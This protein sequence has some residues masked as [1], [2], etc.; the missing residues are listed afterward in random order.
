M[1]FEDINLS[2]K[3]KFEELVVTNCKLNSISDFNFFYLW[4]T[5]S[6]IQLAFERNFVIAKGVW[7]GKSYFY[8]PSMATKE[9][10]EQILEL[11]EQYQNG[12]PFY[13][14]GID[15]YI[16]EQIQ[17]LPSNM[18][19]KLDR[20]ASD[21]L[22]LTSDLA[23]LSGKK[24][25]AKRNFVNSFQR[26]Y[27]Y[28][29]VQYEDKYFDEILALYDEWTVHSEHA[30]DRKEKLAIQ[31]ALQH[32]KP[33]GLTILL[34]LV[35][36]KVVAF[37]VSAISVHNVAQTFFEKANINF[38]GVYAM[39]NNLTATS[40]LDKTEYINREED[41]GIEGLRTAKLSYNPAVIYDKY[42]LE[43]KHNFCDKLK[44]LLKN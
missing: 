3:D 28:Q 1:T 32:H 7:G 26:S 6:N 2:H 40:L 38:K 4:N 31:T 21:Y 22:Y 18:S 41:M 35:D 39:I 44:S 5:N 37:S 17:Q 20:N 33:L 24:F 11:I 29:L 27:K 23:N 12:K 14:A 43:C 15:S 19:I 25:H 13:F 9:D 30:V 8:S 34:L 16:A 10:F 42:I 36:D